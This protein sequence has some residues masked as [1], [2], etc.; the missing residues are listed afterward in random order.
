MIEK[1]QFLSITGPKDD[2]DRFADVYLSK[3]EMHLEYALSELSNVKGLLPFVDSSPYRN[4]N[5]KLEDIMKFISIK[6]YTPSSS[7]TIE[8]A[9]TVIDNAHELNG[10]APYSDLVKNVTKK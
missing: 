5:S 6:N 1:M 9:V 8:E 2:I 7:M 4:I 10:N 3:Y